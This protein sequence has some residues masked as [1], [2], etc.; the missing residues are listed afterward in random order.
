VLP[1][2]LADRSSSGV[3][4]PPPAGE[5]RPPPPASPSGARSTSEIAMP[6]HGDSNPFD[7]PPRQFA[8]PVLCALHEIP[9]A[10]W[11]TDPLGRVRWMNNAA[12][13]L[14]GP[15]AGFHFSRFVAPESVANA[16]EMFARKVHGR[17]DS[18][19]QQLTLNAAAGRVAA[20]L[21]SVPM[22][23]EGKVIGVITLIRPHRLGEGADRRRPQPPLTR[24][25]HEVL[26]LLAHGRSTTEIARA[27]QLSKETVRNHIRN[28]MAELGV[29]TRLEAVVTAFRNGWL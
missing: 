3:A 15:G 1:Q 29:R 18:T 26:E 20:E 22:R 24:R 21:T 7:R 16:R 4:A 28:L 5:E 13:S 2:R 23:E 10:I 19:V 14:L 27:L 17:V 25:Q 12:T 8:E 9:L 11:I 6:P